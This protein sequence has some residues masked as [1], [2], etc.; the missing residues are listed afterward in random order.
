MLPF[1]KEIFTEFLNQ[2]GLLIMGEGLGLN[3]IL[4]SFVRLYACDKALVFLLNMSENDERRMVEELALISE[5][6]S[7][8]FKVIDNTVSSAD[9]YRCAN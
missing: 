9:R 4:N 8:H 5:E 6:L 3:S 2:S 1:Q 7:N